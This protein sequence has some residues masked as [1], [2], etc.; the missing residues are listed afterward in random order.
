MQD[1]S[2]KLGLDIIKNIMINISMAAILVSRVI[3]R[4]E[5]ALSGGRLSIYLKA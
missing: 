3:V 4:N 1:A 2:V 5:R